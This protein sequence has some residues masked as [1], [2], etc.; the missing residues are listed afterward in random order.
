MATSLT[1]DDTLKVA[2]K[3]AKV[4]S[5]K[6]WRPGR[7]VTEQEARAWLNT[8]GTNEER[9]V[10]ECHGSLLSMGAVV[11]SERQGSGSAWV[12]RIGAD[13]CG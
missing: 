3:S 5:R 13:P 7:H 1:I 9:P 4:S 2:K 12:A 11:G 10:P 8:W 6:P